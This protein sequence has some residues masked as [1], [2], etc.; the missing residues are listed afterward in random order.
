MKPYYVT[1][2]LYARF[3]RRVSAHSLNQ[4]VLD[5]VQY[6]RLHDIRALVRADAPPFGE[7]DYH[8]IEV[9]QDMEELSPVPPGQECVPAGPS[10]VR[11]RYPLWPSPSGSCQRR[12]KM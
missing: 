11:Q 5:H 3:A 2:A 1:I 4:M 7:R 12:M 10:F 9:G 6:G 8:Q